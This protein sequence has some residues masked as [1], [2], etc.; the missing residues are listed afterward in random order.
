MENQH[1]HSELTNDQ[2]PQIENPA[3][4]IQ[5]LNPTPKQSQNQEYD[6]STEQYYQQ[7]Q[8][9]QQQIQQPETTTEAK[10]SSHQ[11]EIGMNN[12]QL[13]TIQ[14]N[15]QCSIE[16]NPETVKPQLNIAPPIKSLLS[17]DDDDKEGESTKATVINPNDQNLVQKL[18]QQPQQNSPQKAIV[19]KVTLSDELN[20]FDWFRTTDIINQIAEKAKNS[21]DSVI[22]VL[23]PGM[24]EYLYSGGNINIIVIS[25]SGRLVSP[26][27]DAFQSV[28]GRATVLA[29]KYN[30]PESADGYPV[31]IA[32]GFDGAIVVAQEKIKRLRLDTSSVPQNQVILAVQPCLIS[33]TNSEAASS[34]VTNGLK[35]DENL[36]P[37]WFLTYCMLIEDPVLGSTMNSYSQFIPINTETV[38]TAKEKK[39]PVDFQDNHLGFASS[40]NELIN[41]EHNMEDQDNEWHQRWCG[42]DET[43]IIRNLSTSLAHLYRRKWSNCMS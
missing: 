2:L 34:R 42:V 21:V 38:A 27:R 3:L 19:T 20:I 37:E 6:Y 36:V 24:K 17:N 28:F 32:N 30:H 23:D 15:L 1:P 11:H 13:P 41:F 7:Y 25:D 33:L 4:N 43:D 31:K 29:A 8:Q 10:L 9:Q 35:L 16:S 18:E 26:I 12:Q 22:T 14:P 5:S 39:F 40:L